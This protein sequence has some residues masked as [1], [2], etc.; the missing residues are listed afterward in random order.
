M[1]F[2]E[3]PNTRTYDGDLGWV[4]STLKKMDE[5]LTT[6]VNLNSIT[7]ADPIIWDITTQYAKSVIVL[8][9]NG[10]AYLSKQA[11]PSGVQLSNTDYWLE[12]FNFTEYT[13]TANQNLTVNVETNTT[14][15]THAYSID[16][17]LIWDDVLY[18]VTTAI[19]VDDLLV[20]YPASNY[21]IKHFTVEDFIKAWVTY[22][23]NLI[24]QYKDDID[25]SE[26][27]YRNQLA[28][29]IAETTAS[30]QAQLNAAIAGVTVDSEVIN[31]RIGADNVTYS[32]LGEAIRTQIT[33]VEDQIESNTNRFGLHP[34]T[35]NVGLQFEWVSGGVNGDVGDTINTTVTTTYNHMVADL[36]NV[37]SV[38]VTAEVTA[39]AT[40]PYYV[41]FT[42]DN[43]V[44]IA[45]YL[46]N[47][48][49]TEEKTATIDIL[50][51]Y[52]KMYAM[53][54]HKNLAITETIFVEVQEQIDKINA[55]IGNVKY[56][57]SELDKTESSGG[58]TGEIGDSVT[59]TTTNTYKYTVIDVSGYSEF[60]SFEV[61]TGCSTSDT[62]PYYILFTDSSDVVLERF[63]STPESVGYQTLVVQMKSEYKKM[64]VVCYG[65]NSTITISDIV[66]YSLQEQ[67]DELTSS[68]F[69]LSI[70]YDA[71]EV[72]GGH[73]AKRTGLTF[74]FITDTHSNGVYVS[75]DRQTVYTGLSSEYS[76]SVFKNL[77]NKGCVD[78]GM[79]GGD[80]ISAYD[81]T[82]SNYE[83]E[84][85]KYMSEYTNLNAQCYFVKGNHECNHEDGLYQPEDVIT[86]SE[87]FFNVQKNGL[88]KKVV[89]PDDPYGGYY[90][91]DF[92]DYKV[93]IIGLNAFI[94]PENYGINAHFGDEQ[95]AWFYDTALN[96]TN[97]TD[98]DKWGVIVFVHNRA[99]SSAIRRI[100]YAFIHK[101]TP[102]T[103][104]GHTYLFDVDS[105]GTV[106]ALIHGHNHTDE[107]ENTYD[108]NLIGVSTATA[109]P[110]QTGSDRCLVDI[111]SVIP[112]TN[113]NNSDGV[114]YETRIGRGAS[115]SYSWGSVVARLT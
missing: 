95:I 9:D 79:H 6:F 60:D 3:F 90:Y 98:R 36:V 89:N 71:I 110:S 87:Y 112:D 52:K 8:N 93:R 46:A 113:G 30:L 28:Y 61:T 58:V 21:N 64:Y 68:S 84:L 54:R 11:V 115:R 73:N 15:S 94:D 7:F 32:T 43:D 86:P 25:A 1:S 16:D 104:D 40:Y 62:Y 33:H 27:A 53:C 83:K 72:A 55:Q 48:T 31:A 78:F 5:I 26:L 108:Y 88:G 50:P 66:L 100:L 101:G 80:I 59:I 37:K 102:V 14:R 39:S 65:A 91:V 42:D 107:Y 106:I 103:Y 97:M 18:N 45:R 105:G 20:V 29:D 96:F 69:D 82:K 109:R 13:R 56:V 114:L 74:A 111:F 49:V 4:M 35:K 41:L 76:N 2:F 63:M 44:I 67:I 22:A 70:M 51:I 99:S 23:T 24:N 77:M 10:N 47:S 38:T 19:A 17:W 92:D 57:K 85:F 81:I 12:I 34:L 75:D